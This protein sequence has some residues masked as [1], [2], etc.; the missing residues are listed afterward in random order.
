MYLLTF[1]GGVMI[2]GIVTLFLQGQLNIVI[3]QL[4]EFWQ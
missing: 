3:Q 4:I 2:G 1:I